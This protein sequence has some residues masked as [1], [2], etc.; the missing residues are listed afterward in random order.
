MGTGK[1]LG[2]IIEK[3]TGQTYYNEVTSRFLQP[4]HLT[5]TAPGV[6]TYN[7]VEEWTGGGLVSNSRDLAVWAKTLYEGRAMKG[8]YLK[9]LFHAVPRSGSQWH[10]R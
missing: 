5:L 10:S 6:M 4:L 1:P 3:A 8:P 9:D 2:L 7:P